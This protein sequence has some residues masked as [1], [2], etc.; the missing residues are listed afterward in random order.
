MARANDPIES[1]NRTIFA[2]NRGF[3]RILLKPIAVAYRDVVPAPGR[4]GVHNFL[5]NLRSP[6]VLANDLLQFEAERA[7]VTIGRFVVNTTIG[8][9]G[10][11]DVAT[12]LGLVYHGEDFGQT[13]AVWGIPS[14]PYLMLPFFGPSNPRDAVGLVFDFLIDPFNIWLRNT[15]EEYLVYA[16][17]GFEAVD[18]RARVID[19]LDELERTSLDFYAALRSLYRQRRV[20]EV[21]NGKPSQNV[22]APGMS[23]KNGEGKRPNIKASLTE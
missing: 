23:L 4:R 15:D 18:S 14:G 6:V 17:G 22:P 16:R 11:F 12:E 5:T 20:D 21:N 10:I 1:F 13:L 9:V 19:P 3:D 8:I 2:F 7:S